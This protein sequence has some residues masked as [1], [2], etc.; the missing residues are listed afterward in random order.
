MSYTNVDYVLVMD[1]KITDTIFDMT[2]KYGH[3]R[4]QLQTFA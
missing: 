1:A 2:V 4:Y 3:H